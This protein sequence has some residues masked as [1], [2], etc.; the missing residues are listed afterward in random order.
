MTLA[1]LIQELERRL[2]SCGGFAV[3]TFRKSQLGGAGDP[4]PNLVVGAYA[5]DGGEDIILR[6]GDGGEAGGMPA[7]TLLDL[8]G[9]LRSLQDNRS[10][11]EVECSSEGPAEEWRL[12]FPLAGIAE[13]SAARLIA[14]VTA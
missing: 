9:V 4:E 11:F 7:M 1:G 2:P 8:L 6:V 10:E 5:D 3:V 12:D 13:N 14:L